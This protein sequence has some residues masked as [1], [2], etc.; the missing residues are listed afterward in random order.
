[1]DREKVS[2]DLRVYCTSKRVLEV[3]LLGRQGIERRGHEGQGLRRGEDVRE[4]VL[5]V[6]SEVLLGELTE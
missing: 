6:L 4:N 2:K 5:L 3:C 1:M